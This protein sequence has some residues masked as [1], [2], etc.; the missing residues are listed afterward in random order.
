ML[1]T[2]NYNTYF[3]NA[4]V[5]GR[6]LNLAPAQID[7]ILEDVAGAAVKQTAFLLAENQKDLDRMASTDPKY[8]RLKL[9]ESRIQDIA[10]DIRAVAKLENPLGHVITEYDRPNGL[11]ISKI[12][13]P[14]GIV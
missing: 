7:R 3:E 5:A 14:L 9:T 12:C 6:K 1:T 11:H 13:V 8:D 10:N 4:L 2:L